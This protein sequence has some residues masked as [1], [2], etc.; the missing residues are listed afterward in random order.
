MLTYENQQV[1][2]YFI[3]KNFKVAGF[4]SQPLLVHYQFH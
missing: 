4:Q 1:I 3:I 2:N